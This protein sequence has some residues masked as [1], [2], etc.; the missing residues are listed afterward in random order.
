MLLVSLSRPLRT[1]AYLGRLALFSSSSLAA[2]ASLGL[3]GLLVAA[4]VFAANP[5][6]SVTKAGSGSGALTSDVG[7]IDCGATCVV[8]YTAGTVVSLTATPDSSSV[9]TGWLGDRKS[10]V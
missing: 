8:S 5:I 6:L 1:L 4:S 9:F 3:G 2:S 10:V 7:A